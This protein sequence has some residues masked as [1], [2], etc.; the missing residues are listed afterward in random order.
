MYVLNWIQGGT[1]SSVSDGIVTMCSLLHVLDLCHQGS[2]QITME[3]ITIKTRYTG[4]WLQFQG[5]LQIHL[6]M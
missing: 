2:L 4:N 3:L 1:L 5:S 6:K